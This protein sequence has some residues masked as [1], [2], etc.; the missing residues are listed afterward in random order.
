MSGEIHAIRGIRDDDIDQL[1]L[2]LEPEW[3]CQE[4]CVS[5]VI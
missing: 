3:D 5:G 4:L 2:S 1:G